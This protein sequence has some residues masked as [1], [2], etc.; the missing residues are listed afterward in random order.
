MGRIFIH[1]TAIPFGAGGTQSLEAPPTAGAEGRA[2]A[3]ALGPQAR[4]VYRV[5]ILHILDIPVEKLRT[6]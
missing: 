1:P 2:G 5:P 4:M 3:P 6:R